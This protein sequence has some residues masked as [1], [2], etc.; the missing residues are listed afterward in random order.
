MHYLPI[1]GSQTI[2]ELALEQVKQASLN[3]LQMHKDYLPIQTYPA[4]TVVDGGGF[5]GVNNVPLVRN[6]VGFAAAAA[7]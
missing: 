4:R 5:A 1:V 6:T 3:L 2:I 7:V